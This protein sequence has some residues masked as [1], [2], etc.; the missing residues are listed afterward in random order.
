VRSQ[1]R[2]R[3]TIA[4]NA[5]AGSLAL[6]LMPPRAVTGQGRRAAWIT[7]AATSVVVSFMLVATLAGPT[8]PPGPAG[9]GYLV[10]FALFIFPAYALYQAFRRKLRR[11]LDVQRRSR[12]GLLVG[13]VILTF[14][15]VEPR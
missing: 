14:A 2:S 15:M 11:R 13:D 10:G 3:G 9:V 1:A 4:S 8:A 7:A 5:G 12:Y 6:W